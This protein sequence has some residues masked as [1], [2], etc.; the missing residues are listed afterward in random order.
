MPDWSAISTHLLELAIGAAG[1]WVIAR[2]RKARRDMNAAFRKIREIEK[3]LA[4]VPGAGCQLNG[5]PYGS[6]QAR[7]DDDD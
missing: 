7:G 2:V 4:E 6:T 3:K 1:S 5:C